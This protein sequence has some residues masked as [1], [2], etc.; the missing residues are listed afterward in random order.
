M[1]VHAP[2]DRPAAPQPTRAAPVVQR[3]I[4]IG[5][6]TAVASDK[7]KLI[8]QLQLAA[9]KASVPWDPKFETIVEDE[10]KSEKI[11]RYKDLGELLDDLQVAVSTG[12][13]TAPRSNPKRSLE[14]ARGLR[15]QVKFHSIFEP[16]PSQ[17]NPIAKGFHDYD[18]NMILE[19][20]KGIQVVREEDEYRYYSHKGTSN[21]SNFTINTTG[22]PQNPGYIYT[23][24]NEFAG[25][26]DYRDTTRKWSKQK[27]KQTLRKYMNMGSQYKYP[28]HTVGHLAPFEHSPYVHDTEYTTKKGNTAYVDTDSFDQ[29]VVIENPMVGEQIK[30]SQVEA[31]MMKGE[32]PYF[33]QFPEYSS[34]STSIDTT[35]N[36]KEI[37]PGQTDKYGNAVVS[38]TH[39][40][41][42]NLLFL[43]EK[44]GQR[45]WG[46]FDNTG[47]TRYDTKESVRKKKGYEKRT[48]D[49]TKWK[50]QRVRKGSN[51]KEI[52]K[53]EKQT[54][55]FPHLAEVH[56]PN[57]KRKTR[58][59][60]FDTLKTDVP[61]YM[62]PPP[63]PMYMGEDTPAVTE[64]LPGK[65]AWG[66][67]VQDKKGVWCTVTSVVSYDQDDDESVVELEPIPYS[68]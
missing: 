64:T 6:K 62:T 49:H 22:N 33:M 46:R 61:G 26:L 55:T 38:K 31:P 53:A 57:K 13:L 47:A 17:P 43:I 45:E 28:Q 44:G 65:L 48:S 18:E 12:S 36:S 19:T 32:T 34:T 8:G 63:T 15:D 54:T 16:N 68:F 21:T 60:R 39:T 2:R 24:N 23:N 42:D 4:R 3:V 67:L 27:R 51:P 1:R 37:T 59:T 52:W 20:P 50:G 41:P 29:N 35:Y 14:E 5:G 10:L 40:R 58:E 56:N 30:R 25:N 11:R 7:N 66:M 9:L